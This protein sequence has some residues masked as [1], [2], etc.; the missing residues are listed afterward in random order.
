M[1]NILGGDHGAVSE[2]LYGGYPHVLRA[3]PAASR[4]TCTA[5]T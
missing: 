3:R 5:R 2:N 4:C 1:V